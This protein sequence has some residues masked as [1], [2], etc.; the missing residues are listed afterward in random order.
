MAAKDRTASD[1]SLPSSASLAS[2]CGKKLPVTTPRLKD[3]FLIFPDTGFKIPVA[4]GS[5]AKG[6]SLGSLLDERAI[7]CIAHNVGLVFPKFDAPGFVRAATDGLG[8]LAIM[9]R[10]QHIGHAL[11]RFLPARYDEAAKLLVRSLT[12]PLTQTESNGLAVFFYLPHSAFIENY[13]LDDFEISMHAQYELTRRFTAEF[14]IRNFLIRDAKR[15]LDTMLGWV[16]DPDPHVRRFC[17]E[18]SRPRL[19]WGKRIQAFVK[20]PRPTLPILEALKD[21]RELYVRRS[22]ANHLGDIAKDHP[23]LVFEICA[24]WLRGASDERKWLIR[25]AVRHPAKKGNAV[26]LKLRKAAA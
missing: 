26:A 4:T 18:G 8:P 13:G 22:V 11:R 3:G 15:T 17:S 25:H 5:M 12:P 14:C 16:S 20:D 19:P 7:A 6:G 10:G 24:R 1:I 2:S 23:E 9:Q 21:D